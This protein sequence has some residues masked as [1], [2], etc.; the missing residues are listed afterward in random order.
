MR[1]QHQRVGH[2]KAV[3]YMY[4]RVRHVRHMRFTYNVRLTYIYH[5][6]ARTVRDRTLVA[7]ADALGT[8]ATGPLAAA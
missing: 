1:R 7:G 3:R 2:K 4:T 6:D 8:E 5:A